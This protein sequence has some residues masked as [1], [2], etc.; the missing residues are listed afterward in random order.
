MD[1]IISSQEIT[2]KGQ[3]VADAFR[4]GYEGQSNTLLVEFI[5]MLNSFANKS[6]I[7]K[8]QNFNQLVTAMLNAHQRNDNLFLADIL[9]Y[10][11]LTYLQQPTG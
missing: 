6:K 9:Q 4:L 10:E 5:D 2:A 1:E 11:L 7:N 3:Q 8:N